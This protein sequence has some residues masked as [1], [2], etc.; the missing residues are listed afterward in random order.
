M[1]KIFTLLANYITYNLLNINAETHLG[2]AVHFFIEDITKIFFLTALIIFVMGLFR[3]SLSKEKVKKYINNKPKWMAY[4]LAVLLGWITPFCSCSSIPLFIGF[5]EAGIPLGVTMTFLA[6]SP[7][8]IEAIIILG[9]LIGF[10][11][12]MIFMLVA[13]FAGVLFGL[14]VEKRG[15]SKY[16]N[17]E[18]I[19]GNKRKKEK[20]GGGKCCCSEG[21]QKSG[22]NA[23][24]KNFAL[25]ERASEAWSDVKEILGVIWI[26]IVIGL[27]IGAYLH[28]YVPQE[29]FVKFAGTN[30]FW[31][32]PFSVILGIPLYSNAMGVI[33]IMEAL[34]LKGVPLGT[35]LT[36]MMSI[37]ALSL[38]E[39]IILQKVLKRELIIRFVAFL[40]VSFIIIGLLF[41]FIF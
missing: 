41:N 10:W 25:K 14:T 26:Y 24:T 6:V 34:F 13:G 5:V 8:P 17:S 36:F 40:G 1:F 31:S 7:M 15:W 28:G 16:V 22:G 23:I 19:L 38:P 18:I 12:S 29:F 9:A 3:R 2:K 4:L 20:G 32:V 11:K 27:L 33:P 35:V 21:C 39:I 30:K 37:T